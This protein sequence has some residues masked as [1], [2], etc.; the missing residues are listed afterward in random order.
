MSSDATSPSPT[1]SPA[2]MAPTALPYV[3]APPPITLPPV[4]AGV[5]TMPPAT[6]RAQLP[7]QQELELMPDVEKELEGFDDYVGVFGKTAPSQDEMEQTLTSAYQ[8]A[9]LHMQLVA[10]ERYAHAQKVL[11]WVNL[12]RLLARLAPAFRLAATTD[13]SIAVTHPALG[14]LFGVRAS[15]AR[16]AAAVRKANEEERSAGRPA[17]KGEAGK[18]RE[19]ADAKAALAAQAAGTHAKG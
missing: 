2:E 15:I 14:S 1:E 13:G 7:K 12:R 5:V 9:L 10:W 8:W 17:Y 6:L 19:K 11:A 18:R 4:P 3:K 16:R